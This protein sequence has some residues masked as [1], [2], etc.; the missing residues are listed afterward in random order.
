MSI[1]MKYLRRAVKYFIQMT[2]VVVIIMAAL[3]LLGVVSP[4][5]NVAFRSGWKS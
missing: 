4:D 1:H 2:F 3:M 5:I